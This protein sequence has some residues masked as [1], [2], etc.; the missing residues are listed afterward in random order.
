MEPL[1]S[2][3]RGQSPQGERAGASELIE[4]PCC[5]TLLLANPLSVRELIA[6]F[7]NFETYESDNYLAHYNL[8]ATRLYGD[9]LPGSKGSLHEQIDNRFYFS[10]SGSNGDK[11][12]SSRAPIC[13]W[14]L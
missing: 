8:R 14:N 4:P 6:D 2:E 5:V 7:W 10:G 12:F 13:N 9:L 1:G 3:R 11:T